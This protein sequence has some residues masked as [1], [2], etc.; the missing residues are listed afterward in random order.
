MDGRSRRQAEW[1]QLELLRRWAGCLRVAPTRGTPAGRLGP[2]TARASLPV[3]TAVSGAFLREP[4][5]G[6]S[7]GGSGARR[8]MLPY[9]R[10]S[11]CNVALPTAVAE[12]G[13]SV[14]S[15]LDRRVGG[16]YARQLDPV[17][18]G[19]PGSY[20]MVAAATEV[21]RSDPRIAR[22]TCTGIL[23]A[24]GGKRWFEELAGAA[25]RWSGRGRSP[26]QPGPS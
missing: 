14:L 8:R 3:W 20:R 23:D 16:A 15:R 26:W 4:S 21:V 1:I 11:P 5:I 2:R 25:P 10:P 6:Q 24:K 19:V 22:G 9:R 18:I 17:W 12:A 13:G 7:R